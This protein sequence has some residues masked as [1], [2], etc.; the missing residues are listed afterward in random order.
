MKSLKHLKKEAWKLISVHVRSKDAD[1]RGYVRCY[2]CPHF[3]HWRDLDCGHFIHSKLDYD[4]RNLKPQCARCNRYLHGNLGV[5]AER[6]IVENGMPWLQQLKKDS[7][8]GNNYSRQ[9]LYA[10]ITKYKN[11]TT[12]TSL[13]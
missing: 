5:Y 13:V 2:T 12:P 9:E 6:L 10:I 8:K 4:L 3:S 7:Q 1:W 11:Q